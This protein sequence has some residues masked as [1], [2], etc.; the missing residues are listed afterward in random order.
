MSPGAT[1]HTLLSRSFGVDLRS[2][3]ALRVALGLLLLVDLFERARDLRAHYSEAGVLP[4]AGLLELWPS[5]APWSLHFHASGSEAALWLLF[6]VAALFALSL[7][8]GWHT[9]VAT[10][11]S[12]ILLTSLHRR[13]PLLNFGAD[14]V[15][16]ML[17]FW[18]MFL[19]LGARASLDAWRRSGDDAGGS[20]HY[21]SVASVALL[22]QVAFVYWFAVVRRTT[23]VWWHGEAMHYALHLDLF[24]REPAVWLREVAGL[25]WLLPLLTWATMAIETVGVLIAF[26]PWATAWLRLL[27]IF[28]I[29]S[30]HANFGIFL[31]LGLFPWASVASWLP[32]L[33]A[34]F[35]DFVERRRISESVASQPAG[36]GTSPTR[37]PSRAASALA[38]AALVLV[39][40]LN[41]RQAGVPALG[42]LV[43]DSALQLGRQLRIHQPWAMF[44]P[45][46][47]TG[48]GWFVLAGQRPDGTHLDLLTGAPVSWEKPALVTATF[49]NHRWNVYFYRVEQRGFR[50]LLRHGA[51]WLCA[52]WGSGPLESLQIH[53]IAEPSPGP[54]RVATSAAPQRLLGFDCER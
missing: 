32:F 9:R 46:P 43:P 11:A 33:P 26:S 47:P 12:W 20:H 54:G 49:P 52:E 4:R 13:N 15:M 50:R 53:W 22:L 28:L 8:V 45:G 34:E 36:S 19:P 3:A 30:M 41:F 6:G 25:Q 38:L 42:G 31:D 39:V 24:A 18:S 1:A 17:L 14:Q 7:L 27:A 2:L 29:A 40:G 51:P 10:L 21:F 44:S 5:L 16:A 37:S 23:P 48:D 35:W